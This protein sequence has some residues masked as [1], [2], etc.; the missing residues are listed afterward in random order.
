VL[1]PAI[2]ANPTLTRSLTPTIQS[3][4]YMAEVS[5]IV[6]LHDKEAEVAATLRAA[7]RLTSFVTPHVRSELATSHAS[8][9]ARGSHA[10][11]GLTGPSN[12]DSPV[13]LELLA[14][15]Q[16]SGDNTLSVLSV[17]RE[18]LKGLR[19]VKDVS[20]GSAL[21]YAS[22][23]ARGDVWLV[24]DRPIDPE[25]A[26]WAVSEVLGGKRA[27][28][29]HGELLAMDRQ[30]G[31]QILGRLRGGLVAAQNA[32]QRRLNTERHQLAIR[33]PTGGGALRKA[34]LLLRGGLSRVGL[35]RFDRP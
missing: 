26:G 19:T 31:L 1:H 4:R 10:P 35:G 34:Q 13:G 17:L 20:Q 27:A 11:S 21:R 32:V 2:A 3:E 28:L 24:V 5:V 6:P 12:D 16:R 14:L 22:Q 18:Q 25:L 33:T 29:V 23:I 30:L 9:E 8:S 15:D 7:V